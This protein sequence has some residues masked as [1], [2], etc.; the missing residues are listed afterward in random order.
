MIVATNI[1]RAG[2][3]IQSEAEWARSR[4]L[5]TIEGGAGRLFAGTVL[6]RITSSGKYVPSP[7]SGS[8]GSETA[9][10]VLFDEVDAT[11]GD[12]LATVISSD[13][14]RRSFL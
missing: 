4:G 5:V 2:G 8:D 3:F 9:V 14:R 1:I 10:A 6:G 11:D 13:A 7:D 12:V